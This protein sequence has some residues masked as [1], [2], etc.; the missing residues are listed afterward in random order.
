M[1][2]RDR[3]GAT[4]IWENWEGLDADGNGSLN[5]YSKGAVI[6]FLHEHVAGLRPQPGVPAYERFD[7]RPAPGGGLTS[8]EARLHTPHG[9]I[10]SSWT[11]DGVRFALQ[12][13]VAPGTIARVTLPDG[14]RHDRGPGTHRF[15]SIDERGL[16]A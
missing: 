6:S 4:T 16:S 11:L 5:H 14:A 7:V 1:C 2:I 12:V 9:P 8:A 3:A 13:V 10:A 15:E